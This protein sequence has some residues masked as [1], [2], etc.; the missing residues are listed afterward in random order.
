MSTLDGYVCILSMQICPR[1]CVCVSLSRVV[2]FIP[3]Q[4]E[5]VANDAL[6]KESY[7]GSMLF[8]AT[9]PGTTL[10]P[11]CILKARDN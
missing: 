10:S 9:S 7:T 1:V 2:G 8:L 3:S 4:N 11:S 6:Q 5:T